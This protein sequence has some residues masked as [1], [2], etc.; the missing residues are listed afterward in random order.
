MSIIAQA[1]SKPGYVN[2]AANTVVDLFREHGKPSLEELSRSIWIENLKTRCRKKYPSGRPQ[3]ASQ[4]YFENVHG[5]PDVIEATDPLLLP[6][7]RSKNELACDSLA[8]LPIVPRSSLRVVNDGNSFLLEQCRLVSMNSHVYVA[9]GPI[10]PERAK[11][12]YDEIKNL[13]SLP[14]RHPNIIPSPLALVS[15][16]DSDSRICGW[17]IP[18]HK[19]GNMDCYARQLRSRNL[20]SARLLNRWALQITRALQFLLN[21]GTWHGDIKPDNV[22]ISDNEDAILIDFTRSFCTFAT[23][24]PEIRDHWKGVPGDCIGIPSHWT[25]KA[26]EQS[27]VYSIGR[28][29]YLVR[30]G[31]DMGE[32]YKT[33]GWINA[34]YES[35]VVFDAQSQTP[36]DLQ[37]IIL[38]C[39][40]QQPS[41]RPSLSELQD[42]LL[43]LQKIEE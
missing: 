10:W 42:N 28:T 31:Y 13:C 12:D 36:Q 41:S 26:I 25:L 7:L 29:M 17:L 16:T 39:V 11:Y 5:F 35:R 37:M 1:D 23:A 24:S 20:L 19:K 43:Q 8:E 6:S 33:V 38:R 21:F 40:D 27:E 2:G 30:E 14:E 22:V 34:D 32:L 3:L 18:Y 15:L 9:K 4:F